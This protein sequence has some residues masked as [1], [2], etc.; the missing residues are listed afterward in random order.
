MN[1]KITDYLSE[2]ELSTY[3]ERCGQIANGWLA[4]AIRCELFGDPKE[5]NKEFLG[6][7]RSNGDGPQ[8]RSAMAECAACYE[9]ERWCIWTVRANRSNECTADLLLVE[10][11][12]RIFVEVK[13]YGVK[14]TLHTIEQVVEHGS[15]SNGGAGDPGVDCIEKAVK[16]S[17]HQF[18]SET[19][20]ILLMMPTM[21][22]SGDASRAIYLLGLSLYGFFPSQIE[23]SGYKKIMPNAT[24]SSKDDFSL[25]SAVLLPFYDSDHSLKPAL[26]HNIRATTPLPTN[27]FRESLEYR[28]NVER[29]G[30]WQKYTTG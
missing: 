26:M 8:F 11:D 7:L 4:S 13:H 17:H 20:N 12:Q 15:Y 24:L 6:R 2:Q 16:N 25:L 10:D 28:F 5:P 18:C 1:S 14:T 21:P 9:L 30:N 23:A 19:P 27:L 3:I 29:K 22:T